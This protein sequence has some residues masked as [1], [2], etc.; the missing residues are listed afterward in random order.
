MLD[1]SVATILETS[2][3]LCRCLSAKT[4]IVLYRPS[5]VS[6]STAAG[7]ATR[8]SPA[9]MALTILVAVASRRPSTPGILLEKYAGCNCRLSHHNSLAGY[10]IGCLVIKLQSIKRKIVKTV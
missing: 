2:G 5:Q 4:R 9:V 8:F 6:A 7:M 3:L 10:W 1:F